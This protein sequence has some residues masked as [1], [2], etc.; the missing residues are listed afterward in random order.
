[1][2]G[3]KCMDLPGFLVNTDLSC[4]A[5]AFIGG[6]K[7]PTNLSEIMSVILFQFKK[8]EPTGCAAADGAPFHKLITL[9]VTT[10]SA[11]VH[12]RI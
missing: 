4:Y 9:I 7:E 8:H 5:L 2:V 11:L 6:S 3:L 1:M 10:H 12:A